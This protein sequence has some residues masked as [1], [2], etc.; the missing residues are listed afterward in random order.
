MDIDIETLNTGNFTDRRFSK[1]F[2]L[3]NPNLFF[4]VVGIDCE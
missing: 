2:L 3:P 4:L 1:Y